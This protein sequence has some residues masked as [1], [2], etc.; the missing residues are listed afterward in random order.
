[1]QGSCTEFTLL[2]ENLRVEN[3]FFLLI[4]NQQIY[5]FI[6]EVRVLSNANAQNRF[7]TKDNR[8]GKEGFS[9]YLMI[10]FI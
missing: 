1:M 6:R 8:K 3:I 9:S 5:P 7:L 2:D 4:N 10:I